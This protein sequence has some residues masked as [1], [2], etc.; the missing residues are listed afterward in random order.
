MENLWK[1]WEKHGKFFEIV[2]FF[3]VMY[4]VGKVLLC[5]V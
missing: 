1:N 5:R 4:V 2:D 3:G